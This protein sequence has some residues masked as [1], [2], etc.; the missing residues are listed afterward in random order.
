[1]LFAVGFFVP[2]PFIY[3]RI[4]GKG[5]IILNDLELDRARKQS[6]H[7]RVISLSQ[8]LK[9]L[10]REGKQN[11]ALPEVVQI[12]MREKRLKKITVPAS[13]PHGFARRLR[14]LKI[15]VKVKNGSLFPEREIKSADEVKKVSAALMMAEVGL[16]EGIQLLKRARIGKGKKLFHNNLPLT[17]DKLRAI[18]DMA[19]IQAGGLACHTIVAGGKQACD[20]HERGYGPLRGNEAIILDVF[21]R[22]QK[23]GYFGDITRTVVKGRASEGVRRLYH[24][25]LRGQELAL[26]RIRHNIPA[27]EVHQEVQRFFEKEGFKTSRRRGHMEGFFHG[28]GRGLGLEIHEAPRLNE[29]SNDILKGGH[30]VTVEPGLYYP[31]IGG[32]RLED[33]VWVTRS[34]PK[35]LTKFEKMLEI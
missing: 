15:K 2:D 5:H 3:L 18:I 16:S 6:P 20:P 31:G 22:S 8:C 34:S 10:R 17:S 32:V 24:T 9:K 19:I 26:Q 25:V 23:T 27:A 35:N 1:M 4:K 21:P 33:V 30:L 29:T 11:P 12:L 28:T 14:E 7:C 13:F